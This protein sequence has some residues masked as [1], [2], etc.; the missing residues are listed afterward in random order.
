[1]NT[2]FQGYLSDWIH[3]YGLVD[4]RLNYPNL[5]VNFISYDRK[6]ICAAF[7]DE[8]ALPS[9]AATDTPGA[10]TAFIA[11]YNNLAGAKHGFGLRFTSSTATSAAL[12]SVFGG[13]DVQV[14]GTLVGDH[15]VTVPTTNPI[16]NSGVN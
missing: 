7:S 11:H 9:L 5:A 8:A 6:T 14:S 1:M 16:Y 2:P 10:G 13:K 4:N 12:I 15:R 3:V